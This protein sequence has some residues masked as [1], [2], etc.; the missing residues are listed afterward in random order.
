MMQD[1]EYLK[2]LVATEWYLR[3]S[4][5]G[6]WKTCGGPA[7]PAIKTVYLERRKGREILREVHG[8]REG[9]RG[10]KYKVLET[11]MRTVM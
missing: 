6:D 3:G 4:E 1:H 10:Y 8:W 5:M 7:E 9:V 2:R 11:K